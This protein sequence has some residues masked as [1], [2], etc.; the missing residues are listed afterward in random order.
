VVEFCVVLMSV[1]AINHFGL[2]L[3]TGSTSV[4]TSMFTLTAISGIGQTPCSFEHYLVASILVLKFLSSS[5]N[6]A[7]PT[8]PLRLVSIWL[9]SDHSVVKFRVM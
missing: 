9:V 3:L 1:H 8:G 4:S 2:Y 6:R 5:L 7:W